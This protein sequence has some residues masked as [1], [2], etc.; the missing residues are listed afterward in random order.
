MKQLAAK[1]AMTLIGLMAVLS[2]NAQA[3]QKQTLGKWDVHY[4]VVS[5]PFLTADVAASYGIVRSKFNALVN[6][7]VL[8]KT[9]GKAQRVSVS[10]NATNLLGNSRQLS[11]KKVEEG[12]AIYYLAV[13]PFRDQETFRFT[14]DVADGK[15]QETLKFQQKMYVDE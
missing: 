12:D 14:I 7:S 1:M 3:E 13:L 11:F 9:S 6:I 4:M 15:R 8:D 2:F 5:T 10:G